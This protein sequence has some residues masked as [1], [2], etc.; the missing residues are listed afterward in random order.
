MQIVE[1]A[2]RMSPAGGERDVAVR[3]QRLEAGVAIHL[4]HTPE[5]GKV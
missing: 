2:P 4:Q 3:S 1:F 5:V